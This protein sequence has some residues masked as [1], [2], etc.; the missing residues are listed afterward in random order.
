M[1]AA[2]GTDAERRERED[3]ESELCGATCLHADDKEIGRERKKKKKEIRVK[4]RKPVAA[5]VIFKKVFEVRFP[6]SEFFSLLD[7]RMCT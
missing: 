1:C 6:S 7:S 5:A 2:R 3:G 4:D